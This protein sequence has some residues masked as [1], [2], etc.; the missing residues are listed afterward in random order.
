MTPKMRRSWGGAR[1]QA[2]RSATVRPCQDL[3]CNPAAGSRRSQR[4]GSIPRS[5]RASLW[6]PP[7]LAVTHVRSSAHR[8]GWDT[9]RS[10]GSEQPRSDDRE[11]ALAC[12]RWLGCAGLD[13]AVTPKGHPGRASDRRPPP[14]PVPSGRQQVRPHRDRRGSRAAREPG[15]AHRPRRSAAD[16]GAGRQDGRSP[17]PH[18]VAIAATTREEIT[19]LIAYRR[20]SQ[21]PRSFRQEPYRC[22]CG[23]PPPPVQETPAAVQARRRC[24]AHRR[25][26]AAACS[27]RAAGTEPARVPEPARRRCPEVRVGTRSA[28]TARWPSWSSAWLKNRR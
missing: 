20:R 19:P 23:V 16:P 11:P 17:A 12:L 13:S 27:E 7:G 6:P 4:Q 5:R 26:R 14:G 10:D 9:G 15:D 8:A 22:A 2:T 18:L 21:S 24:R 3:G 1:H 25:C 28:S